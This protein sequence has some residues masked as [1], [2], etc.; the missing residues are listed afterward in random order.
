MTI[1]LEKKKC[2]FYIL[3][4]NVLRIFDVFLNNT[5]PI[6][7]AIDGNKR[8]ANALENI[9]KWTKLYGSSIG[10]YLKMIRHN[11]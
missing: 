1:C 5:F 6:T 7:V 3:T 10:S 9:L 8:P 4:R 2:I 11:L